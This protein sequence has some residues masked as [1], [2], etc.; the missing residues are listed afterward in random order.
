M[1]KMAY[2]KQRKFNGEYYIA[3]DIET[4]K[5][6]AKQLARKYRRKGYKAR[7]TESNPRYFTGKFYTVWVRR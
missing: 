7:I 2:K 1:P 3:S 5:R 4:S 6:V